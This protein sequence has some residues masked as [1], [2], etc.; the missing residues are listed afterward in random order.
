MFF[1]DVFEASVYRRVSLILTNLNVRD[2]VICEYLVLSF[3]V[4]GHGSQIFPLLVVRWRHRIVSH[5]RDDTVIWKFYFR[6]QSFKNTSV[7]FRNR[8]RAFKS[9]QAII[10]FVRVFINAQDGY[11]RAPGRNYRLCCVFVWRARSSLCVDVH[12]LLPFGVVVSG[13]PED[14]FSPY[15]WRNTIFTPYR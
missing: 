8:Q 5:A 13:A 12:F 1:Y 3:R 9:V 14:R 15:T 2:R 4:V 10:T 6:R 7:R 11:R